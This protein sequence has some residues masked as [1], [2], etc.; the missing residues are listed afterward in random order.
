M[1]EKDKR[2]RKKNFSHDEIMIL[3]EGYKENQSILESKFNSCVT[4]RKKNDAWNKILNEINAK[5]CQER[6]I[7]E[8]KKKWSDL[9]TQGNLYEL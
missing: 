6:E 1:A 8:I 2:N 9:K 5:G 7:K 3:L 4:N